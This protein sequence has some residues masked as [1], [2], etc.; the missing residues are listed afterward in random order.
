VRQN[1]HDF[2]RQVGRQEP[3]V[4]FFRPRRKAACNV[5]LRHIDCYDER[6]IFRLDSL[7][8]TDPLRPKVG[9][10]RIVLHPQ[11]AH[12][13]PSSG[14]TPF[15][16]PNRQ[17][18]VRWARRTCSERRTPENLQLRPFSRPGFP[19]QSWDW[20]TGTPHN[21]SCP[22][23]RT[24]ALGSSPDEPCPR[25]RYRSFQG[26]SIPEASIEFG[27]HRECAFV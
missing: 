10:R 11:P 5:S 4:D 22:V 16:F 1:T 17:N 24:H 25:P 15:S 2:G 26:T 21:R 27:H 8:I 13:A 12:P 9:S 14:T 6:L 3:A 23:Q 19:L 7:K 20:Q 18:K